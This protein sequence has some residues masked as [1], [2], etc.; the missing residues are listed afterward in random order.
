MN[1][2]PDVRFVR[3]G[4]EV[5]PGMYELEDVPE[6]SPVIAAPFHHD[7]VERLN[8]HQAQKHQHFYTCPRHPSVD[9]FCTRDGWI[10]ARK[11]CKYRQPWAYATHAGKAPLDRR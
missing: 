10:C 6:L 8:D 5:L 7:I 9:L 2:D 4:K 1:T 11:G 3:A